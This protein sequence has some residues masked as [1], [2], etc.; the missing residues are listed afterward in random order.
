MCNLHSHSTQLGITVLIPEVN[1]KQFVLSVPIAQTYDGDAHMWL[2]AGGVILGPI[3]VDA[4][5]ATPSHD[6]LISQKRFLEIHDNRT[7]R[8]EF[9]WWHGDPPN[10]GK[11]CGCLGGCR[12]FGSNRNGPSFFNPSNQDFADS[13]N[14]AVINIC[15]DG[16]YYG[17]GQSLLQPNQ[18]VFDLKTLSAPHSQK[19]GGMPMRRMRSEDDADGNKTLTRKTARCQDDSE[20]CAAAP[21]T[22]GTLVNWEEIDPIVCSANE[23]IA[24]PWDYNRLSSVEERDVE[25]GSI[26]NGTSDDLTRSKQ[27]PDA[28]ELDRYAFIKSKMFPLNEQ[29]S[30]SSLAEGTQRYQKSLFPAQLGHERKR[31]YD[32]PRTFLAMSDSVSPD[33]GEH[34]LSHGSRGSLGSVGGTAAA[35]NGALSRHSSLTSPVLRRLS[36]QNDS[37][38]TSIGNSDKFFSATEVGSSSAGSLSSSVEKA[39]KAKMLGTFSGGQ[40]VTGS[41]PGLHSGVRSPDSDAQSSSVT[42]FYDNA[43]EY[44]PADSSTDADSFVSACS[45]HNLTG[46]SRAPESSE[47]DMTCLAEDDESLETDATQV[48]FAVNFVD[49]HGQINQPITKSPLLMSCY[50]S[51]MTRLHCSGWSVPVG[52]YH[53]NGASPSNSN[54]ADSGQNGYRA[55]QNNLMGIPEFSYLT[56]GFTTKLMV[57]KHLPGSPLTPSSGSNTSEATTRP[58]QEINSLSEAPCSG[59]MLA[60]NL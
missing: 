43:A 49:L 58:H 21:P 39:M 34:A 45:S 29:G 15:T 60:L 14:A 25:T 55:V 24:P 57:S 47:D 52:P 53:G 17:Y 6:F 44:H 19:T 37:S 28:F 2:E 35:D 48:P 41:A 11:V 36:S 9:L 7:R 5:V 18:L 22:V 4:A 10:V 13:T 51:H 31:S 27:F 56:E 8:L 59:E 40:P 23:E 30:A 33:G 42:S 46:A 38:L 20:R 32:P 54:H 26:S 12:F 1:V 50:M 3:I 16:S